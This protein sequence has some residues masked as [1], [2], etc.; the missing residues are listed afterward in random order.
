MG[1]DLT[2]LNGPQSADLTFMGGKLSFR[3]FEFGAFA[4]FWA[5]DR[6]WRRTLLSKVQSDVVEE[7][8]AHSYTPQIEYEPAEEPE[9][10]GAA[11]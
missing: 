4:L 10:A 11:Y 8:A 6:M 3:I 1:I 5:V 9:P 2:H 7:G